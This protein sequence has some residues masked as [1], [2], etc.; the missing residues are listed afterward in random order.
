MR[1]A[2]KVNCLY[3]YDD[4]EHYTLSIRS[5]DA[6]EAKHKHDILESSTHAKTARTSFCKAHTHTRTPFEKMLGKNKSLVN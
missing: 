4:T 1:T 3:Y 2:R 6:R 5:Q